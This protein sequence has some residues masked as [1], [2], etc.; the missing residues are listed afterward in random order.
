MEIATDRSLKLKVVRDNISEGRARSDV[1]FI[2]TAG[3]SQRA[4]SSVNHTSG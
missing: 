2:G 1:T 3:L 4:A